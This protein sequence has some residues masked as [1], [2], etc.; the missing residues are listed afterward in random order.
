MNDEAVAG[1]RASLY[2]ETIDPA[3]PAYD[4]ARRVYNGMIDKRPAL[5]A[6]CRTTADV[7]AAVRWAGEHDLSIGVRGGGHSVAGHGTC[8]G[9]LLVDLSQMRGVQVD[10]AARTAWVQGGATL[11]DVDRE[12][13]VYGL[14]TP[15]G[16]VSATGIAGLTLNGGMGML[17][18][19]YSLTCDN[20]VAARVVTAAGSIVTANANENPE[21]FWALRGGGG[22][23]GAVTAFQFQLH[24]VGPLM[25]AGLIAYPIDEAVAVLE[26][27]RDFIATAPEELSADVIFQF[28][29]P[30]E[31]IPEQFRG[32]QVVGI[33]VRWCGGIEQGFEAIR[34]LQ[35]FGT[36]VL[37]FI[38]PMPLVAVQSMLDPLNP[39]GNLHY[40]TGEFL[41]SFGTKEME[42]VAEIG[43]G[44]PDS[45]LDRA[46]DSL[47]RR[48]D[49]G[50]TRRH[51]LR[52][53][54]RELAHPRARAV[55]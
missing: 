17:Q 48:P 4:Q 12:T 51:R 16:Q 45:S 39:N 8:D 15:T 24:P 38:G 47:Q 54:Q 43:A 55:A 52:P 40:W 50:G 9:G 27:L 44:L 7:T 32:R 10:P 5:I 49:P 31:V 34:P 20:L 28:A 37:N 26:F 36:P 21:L 25:L 1:L 30:L 42:T 6:R 33:F 11:G 13:Q 19:K 53:P 35:A 29:P 18:R 23:F 46:G 3:H 41:P 2:G 22:N 14:A